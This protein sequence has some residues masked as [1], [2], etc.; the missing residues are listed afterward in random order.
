MLRDLREKI[1]ELKLAKKK[2]KP[3][4]TRLTD[5]EKAIVITIQLC[6]NVSC[7]LST[8]A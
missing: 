3:I 5:S 4:F 1:L 2:T 8:A 7:M 6:F